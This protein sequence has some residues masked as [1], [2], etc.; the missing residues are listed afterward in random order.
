MAGKA[1]GSVCGERRGGRKGTVD[2]K[3]G[4][5][6]L[7]VGSSGKKVTF[8]NTEGLNRKEVTELIEK[9]RKEFDAKLWEAKEKW[10]EM[11]EKVKELEERIKGYE[12][13]IKELKEGLKSERDDSGRIEVR[14]N[15]SIATSRRSNYR[16]GGSRASSNEKRNESCDRLSVR[17]VG[18]VRRLMNKQEKER[19]RDNIIIKGMEI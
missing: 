13:E 12:K 1:A 17:K 6:V 18:R 14:S 4:K 3:Q 2:E 15:Y 19:R 9:L 7:E 5:L 8:K 10:G 16:G 11:A